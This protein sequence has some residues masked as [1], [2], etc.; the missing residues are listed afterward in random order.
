M[1]NREQNMTII[2]KQKAKQMEERFSE[3]RTLMVTAN[4][5][6][7]ISNSELFV[8]QKSNPSHDFQGLKKKREKAS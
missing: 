4:Q 2:I 1:D 6:I 5:T 3:Y 8:L 7:N